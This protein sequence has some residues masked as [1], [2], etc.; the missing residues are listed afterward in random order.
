MQLPS[1]RRRAT[2]VDTLFGAVDDPQLRSPLLQELGQIFGATTA[3]LGLLSAAPEG[4][5]AK[6]A[7]WTMESLTMSGM[8]RDA[9]DAFASNWITR[10]GTTLPSLRDLFRSKV[11]TGVYV[12]QQYVPDAAF[13]RSAFFN[14]FTRPLDQYHYMWSLG[15]FPGG[16]GWWAFNLCRPRRAGEFGAEETSV[17]NWLVPHLHRAQ[18]LQLRLLELE[19][20]SGVRMDALDALPAPCLAAR[21]DGR[22]L[23]ANAAAEELLRRADGLVVR[24]GRLGA[25]VPWQSAAVLEAV[26]TCAGYGVRTLDLLRRPP[27]RPLRATFLPSFAGTNKV[28]GPAATV[29]LL[30]DPDAAPGP[31]RGPVH[32]LLHCTPSEGRVAALLADGLGLPQIAERLGITVGTVRNHLKQLYSKTGTHRQAELVGLVLRGSG[33]AE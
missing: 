17:L 24:A 29:V 27:A 16:R 22:L 5:E 11:P 1:S 4:P 8:P 2:L 32:L 19:R 28:A 26:R 12:R 33:P 21:I 13:E 7:P 14:E 30:E 25:S 9:V 3:G 6:G 15:R 10:D 18:R 20:V 23:W 31:P